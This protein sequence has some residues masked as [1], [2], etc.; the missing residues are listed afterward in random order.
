[1]AD[2]RT[3]TAYDLVAQDG[4]LAGADQM[5]SR[6]DHLTLDLQPRR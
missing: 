4:D 5:P 6:L 3:T 1:M 2:G